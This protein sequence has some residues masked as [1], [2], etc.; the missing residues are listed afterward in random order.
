MNKSAKTKPLHWRSFISFVLTLSFCAMVFSG[1]VLYLSPP[2]GLARMTGWRFWTLG[3]DG[4]MA[5]HMTSCTVFL[6]AG[7]I[8]LYL[9]IRAL[10]SY[11]HSKT[12]RDIRRKWELLASL[13][14]IVFM[15]T[16][17]LWKLPPWK[18]ILD[19]SRHLKAYQREATSEHKSHGYRRQTRDTEDNGSNESRRRKGRGLH[20]VR[21]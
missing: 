15:V 6:L 5:Q 8:H 11:I 1:V 7:L 17:T 4:W 20:S 13:V 2:G 12:A 10:W 3:K 16:G 14:L 21:E 18:S 19:G 9:N